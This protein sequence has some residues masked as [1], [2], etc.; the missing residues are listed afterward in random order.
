MENK[1]P[2]TFSQPHIPFFRRFGILQFYSKLGRVVEER[3]ERLALVF[4]LTRA[5][6][7]TALP[8]LTETV[9]YAI[10]Q[11]RICRS[12][13]L[14]FF[15]TKKVNKIRLKVENSFSDRERN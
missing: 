14:H 9:S 12:F 7:R 3:A 4:S 6:V 1:K 8:T 2:S 10:T 15:V 5:A 11:W 13:E